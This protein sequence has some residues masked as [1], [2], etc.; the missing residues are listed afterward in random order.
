MTRK[1]FNLL[2][3]TIK[4]LP[5]F[6][7]HQAD[8]KLYPCD[9][10]NFDALTP[11]SGSIDEYLVSSKAATTPGSTFVKVT[12]RHYALFT[13]IASA[14]PEAVTPFVFTFVFLYQQAAVSLASSINESHC[15]F[16]P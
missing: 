4:Q 13:T 3:E 7:T 8:G 5:S 12:T 14:L 16:L 6:E 10:V 2:A 15:C 11:L 9:V 1:D